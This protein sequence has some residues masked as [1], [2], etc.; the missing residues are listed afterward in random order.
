MVSSLL[1][2]VFD[3]VGCCVLLYGYLW[4]V[5]GCFGFCNLV[6]ASWFATCCSVLRFGFGL[7]GSCLRLDVGC[8]VVLISVLELA[9]F[10]GLDL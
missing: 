4:L 6:C 2:L 9:D 7:F 1:G 8:L 3:F 10:P 5:F